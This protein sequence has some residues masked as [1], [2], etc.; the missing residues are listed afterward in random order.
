MNYNISL[1]GSRVVK[2]ALGL[3]T[4]IYL[5][6]GQKPTLTMRGPCGAVQSQKLG[7]HINWLQVQPSLNTSHC[8]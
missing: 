5:E 8:A 6:W 3:G 1:Q 2:L 7:L 4:Q